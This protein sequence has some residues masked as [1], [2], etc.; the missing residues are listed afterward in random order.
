[1]SAGLVNARVAGRQT[2]ARPRVI[3]KHVDTARGVRD[4]REL[5]AELLEALLDLQGLLELHQEALL[6]TP[7]AGSDPALARLLEE[8]MYRRGVGLHRLRVALESLEQLGE[9]VTHGS[10]SRVSLSGSS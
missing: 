8:R 4:R 2:A 10:T 5:A 9:P 6:H 3:P 1:P 7:R